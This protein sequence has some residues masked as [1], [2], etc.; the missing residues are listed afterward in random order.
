MLNARALMQQGLRLNEESHTLW[1]EYLRLEMLYVNQIRSRQ[2]I[3]GTQQDAKTNMLQGIVAGVVYDNAIEKFPEDLDFRLKMAKIA[4]E[5]QGVDALLDKIYTSI[6]KDFSKKVDGYVALANRHVLEAGKE[7]DG[8]AIEKCVSVFEKSALK[9]LEHTPEMWNAYADM[10]LT[11]LE[12]TKIDANV[13]T[14]HLTRVFT[15][16][17]E[18]E[19]LSPGLYSKWI[20][21]LVKQ[22]ALG[23]AM[24]VAERGLEDYPYEASLWEHYLKLTVMTKGTEDADEHV[25]LAVEKA[26]S[27]IVSAG[28]DDAVTILRVLLHVMIV[29]GCE[30]TQI[31]PAV[32][33]HLSKLNAEMDW[34]KL[35]YLQWTMTCMPAEKARIAYSNVLRSSKSSVPVYGLCISYEK[36]RMSS[37][38]VVTKLYEQ[39]VSLHGTSSADL[40]LAY[41][42]DKQRSG[43]IQEVGKLYFRATKTLEDSI[44][45]AKL[46]S[47]VNA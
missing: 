8:D 28:K 10:L 23:D 25:A 14:K 41:I 22:A 26:M 35:A 43:E 12:S 15:R 29:V 17:E 39:A 37:A 44:D 3:L 11:H 21:V 2:V 6:T 31:T 5:F 19:S 4:H 16:A 32:E 34:L 7:A 33:R 46:S 9:S 47:Y 30:V 13:L 38:A 42:S 18:E 20:G 24:A 36:S 40:W 45:V 27:A 1:C